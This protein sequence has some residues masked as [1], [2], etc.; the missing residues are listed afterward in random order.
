MNWLD[1]GI[2]L[3]V[4]LFIVIGVRRGFMK[5]ILSHFSLA[6]NCLISFFLCQPIKWLLQKIGLYGAIY[7]SYSTRLIASSPSLSTNL[8]GLTGSELSGAISDGINNSGLSKLSQT[9]FKWFLKPGTVENTLSSS[10]DVT[11]RT[12][13]DIISSTYANFFTSIIAFVSCVIIVYFLVFLFK[14]LAEKLRQSGF[15][16]VVDGI[17]GSV[18]G[19]FRCFVIL[20]IVCLVLK[21]FSSFSFMS[22]VISYI[23]GSFFGKLIYNQINSL[24]NTFFKLW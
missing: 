14:K 10:P 12:M 21:I 23:D 3:F 4:I 8:V 13:S 7:S 22:G 5:S 15:V 11:S 19:V 16:R 20:L 17:F 24:I 2:I 6:V 18:Y 9:F 1:L